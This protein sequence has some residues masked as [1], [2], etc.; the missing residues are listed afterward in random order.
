MRLFP[1]YS[2]EELVCTVPDHRPNCFFDQFATRYDRHCDLFVLFLVGFK[3]DPVDLFCPV[4]DYGW[5]L[6]NALQ[7]KAAS[8]DRIRV[9]DV[10]AFLTADQINC[11]RAIVIATGNSNHCI[12]IHDAI[13]KAATFGG[14]EG[15]V[16]YVHD[17][18]LLNLIQPGAM[19]S[20][21][22]LHQTL[23]RLYNRKIR[24]EPAESSEQWSS[25]CRTYSRRSVLV[26]GF[27]QMRA[28]NATS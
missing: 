8:Q 6:G 23:E 28:S 4:D 21:E 2:F 25:S 15:F 9:F 1:N 10:G 7:L 12:Y 14:L 13:K 11:Y 17:P 26:C 3:K 22:E 27:F 18:C 24:L 20:T 16:L 5:F 19:L